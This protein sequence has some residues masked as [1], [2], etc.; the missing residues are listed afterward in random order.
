MNRLGLQL[1]DTTQLLNGF[2]SRAGPALDRAAR[3]P[4]AGLLFRRRTAALISRLAILGGFSIIGMIL[5]WPIFGPDF[6][7]GVDTATFLHLSWVTQ[8]AASGQLA[9]PFQDPYWYGGFSYLVAYPPLGYGA[10][11]VIS[12]ITR[13]GLVDVYNVVLVVSFGGTATAAYW[14]ALELG[15][16]RGTAALVGVLLALS[17]PLL[18]AAFLW[19]WF[20]SLMAL[21]F[22]LIAVMLIDRSIRLGGCKTAAWAGLFMAISVLIHH[23]TALALGLGL[24]G[25]FVFHLAWGGYPRRRVL[26]S[27]VVFIGAAAVVVA[28]WGIPFLIHSL[29]AGFRREVPGLWLPNLGLYREFIVDRSLIGEF[30][31]PSYLG[32]TLMVLATAGTVYALIERRRLAGFAIV[33]LVLTWFSM[34]ANLN[35][36]IKVYPFSGLD[37]ARFHLYMVPFMAI[38][39]GAVVERA[40]VALRDLW[41]TT[42]G[43]LTSRQSRALGYTVIA[44]AIAA[45]LAFSSLDAAKARGTMEPYKVDASVGQAMDWLALEGR[46]DRHTDRV[47]V[48]SLGL[49]NWDAFI[50]PFFSD[51]PLI[52]GWHDEGASNVEKIRTL[53]IMG[54]TG[55]V[56]IVEAHRLMWELGAQYV[57]VDRISDYLSEASNV[58]WDEM[59]A[60]P[61]LF[62]KQEQWDDV[63]IFQVL[64]S[65]AEDGL[66]RSTRQPSPATPNKI[67]DFQIAASG[68]H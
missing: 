6:P 59:E 12:F 36:L 30:V 17:Y 25:W 44:A 50:I 46:G 37:T 9:D 66:P 23:M 39:A 65:S 29:D 22:G 57:L 16:R 2:I 62:E 60:H 42:V 61:E 56:D 48:Y 43:R 41:P 33:L 10:V 15:L 51:Q 3:W 55:D 45:I 35:P 34:G 27:S 5:L 18:S 54:W 14:L 40:L 52:D 63:A 64:S 11:G 8:L 24:V 26:E 58:F 21:P 67:H 32:I 20:T 38:M 13:L 49:W 28:P 31:Y 53:R 7:S 47:Q 1:R 4:V 68:A 19:G